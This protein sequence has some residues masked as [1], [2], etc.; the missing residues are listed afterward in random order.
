MDNAADLR[1]PGSRRAGR[2]DGAKHTLSNLRDRSAS[3]AEQNSGRLA[4]GLGW[5]AVGLG[6]AQ[7]VMPDRVAEVAGIEPTTDNMRLMRSMGVRELTSG[8]G[9]L[10][11]PTPDKWLWGRVAG[12]VLDLA[13]LG[14][15]L[16]QDRNKRG[17]TLGATLAVLGVTGLDILAARELAR[18]REQSAGEG[19][20]AGEKTLFRIITVKSHPANVENDWNEFVANQGSE[21]SREARM[22]FRAAPG[23]RGTEIR[24]E[25]TWRPRA[26]KI[27]E[28]VQRMRHKSPGQTL[29]H[30]LKLF[31]MLCETG[32]IVKSDASIHTHMHPAQPD[33][34]IPRVARDD[35]RVARDDNRQEEAR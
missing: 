1:A 10:T 25:L 27:G 34:Q 13:M 17:R 3:L 32:E 5:F 7:I 26:G 14:V 22:E 2:L 29:G 23:G 28:T 16:S 24:A 4:N 6:L 35:N 9:I 21:E 20:E 11:Q 33:V 12:D 18:Q 8:V 19:E 30:D 15:A 31:K